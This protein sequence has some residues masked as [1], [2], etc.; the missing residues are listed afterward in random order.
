MKPYPLEGLKVLDFSR[1]LSGPYA[2]RMLADLGADVL[3]I[4]PPE[5]DVTRQLGRRF[6]NSSGFYVQ[7]NV[8]KRNICIDMKAEGARELILDL[9]AKADLVVEN[10]RPGVMAKFGL[11]WDNLKT[12][13]E[14]LVMV[15]I[16][17]FGQTSSAKHRAAY[18]PV[19]HAETS[20]ISRQ[21]EGVGSTAGDI[22]F[23]IADTYS[24]LHALTGALVALRE[25]DR[26]GK[27]QHLDIAMFNVMHATDDYAHYALEN[28]WPRPEESLIVP[29]GDKR[30]LISGSLMWLWKVF[31]VKASLV[32][33]TP[34]GADLQTKAAMRRQ[35]II[36]HLASFN[37]FETL[38]VY[39]DESNLAWGEVKDFNRE[40]YDDPLMDES[41]VLVDVEDE[42]GDTRT[43][44]Q[45]PYR[46]SGLSSGT[47]ERARAPG[48]GQDNHS[49]LQDWIGLSEKDVDG[50]LTMG[51]LKT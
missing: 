10:F 29:A 5:G 31:S 48:R 30:V 19:L 28:A 42:N 50:L 21:A 20:V 45:S 40:L 4:E 34:E 35:V 1:V 37:S 36:D 51:I 27:G 38:T 9:V 12:V 3:K 14:R 17:G 23:S 15:S 8:G 26:T 41:G 6:G 33:P 13:N 2:T 18:A 25:V 11:D 44:V 16:S 24:S 22:Q 49:A 39:L 7:Q 46:F 47:K 43:T 32:D